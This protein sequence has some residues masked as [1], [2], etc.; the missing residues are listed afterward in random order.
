MLKRA[1]YVACSPCPGGEAS[2]F[3]MPCVSR[4]FVHLISGYSFPQFCEDFQDVIGDAGDEAGNCLRLQDG[5][6][7]YEDSRINSSA[8]RSVQCVMAGL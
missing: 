8:F 1:A 5:C 2:E 3:L 7:R 6:G 4:A